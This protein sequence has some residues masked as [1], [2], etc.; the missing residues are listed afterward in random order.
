MGMFDKPVEP[1]TPIDD[2]NVVY[3]SIHDTVYFVGGG[4]PMTIMSI[5]E[6]TKDNTIKWV[7][8]GWFD[9]YDNFH[10]SLFDIKHLT[11]G[12]DMED[13]ED[14]ASSDAED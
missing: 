2:E 7:T 14:Y 8:V 11:H 1:L 9:C 3:F 13:V 5:T 12:E 6:D 10:S 4:P